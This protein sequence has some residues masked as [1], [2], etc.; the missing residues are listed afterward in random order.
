MTQIPLAH[1]WACPQAVLIILPANK[2]SVSL[3]FPTNVIPVTGMLKGRIS[4]M[5]LLVGGEA[6]ER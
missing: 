1:C 4:K 6:A 5:Q 3:T 2:L